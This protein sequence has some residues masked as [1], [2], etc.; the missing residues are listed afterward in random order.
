MPKVTARKLF[1]IACITGLAI[2][3]VSVGHAKRTAGAEETREKT[4]AQCKAA[5][6]C[7][8]IRTR[9]CR[10]L[11]AFKSG[12]LPLTPVSSGRATTLN[13]ASG[14]CGPS[15]LTRIAANTGF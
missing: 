13:S 10:T 3:A 12:Y 1:L 4:A 2:A 5:E 14:Q 7:P 8:V 15:R 11:T 9:M 6:M